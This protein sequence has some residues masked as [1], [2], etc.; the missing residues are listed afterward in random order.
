MQADDLLNLIKAIE[1]E[2]IKE[3]C[4]PTS[5]TILELKRR[6]ST[7]IMPA[8]VELEKSGKVFIG[9]TKNGQYVRRLV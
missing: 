1:D 9:Q 4:W 7:D 2:K 8:L 5:S 3:S 6:S